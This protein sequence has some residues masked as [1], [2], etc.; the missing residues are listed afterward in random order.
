MSSEQPAGA[1]ALEAEV[2]VEVPF[3]DADPMGVT[4]HGNYFRYLETAR[5]A[6][7][8]KIGYGFAEMSASGFLWPIVDAR[9]KYVK[10]TSFG[11]HLKI[12]AV[13]DEYENRLKIEYVISDS[14][15]SEVVTKATTTQV[16]VDKASGELCFCS[17]Q[18]LLDKVERCTRSS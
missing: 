14:R 1:A 3:H 18:I 13:L 8:K 11:Q 17:P 16:A 6:L 9:I 15:T 7:L 12:K 10:P 5:S 2:E 4:W